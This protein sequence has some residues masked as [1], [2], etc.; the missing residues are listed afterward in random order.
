MDKG[1]CALF[2]AKPGPVTL[3]SLLPRGDEYQVAVLEGEA[4]STPMV[5]PGN[6]LRAHF[7]C[8]AGRLIAWIYDEG[9]G[10]HWMAGYGHVGD[11]IRQWAKIVGAGVR[12]V[13][14]PDIAV[15]P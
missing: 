6:P 15:L 3:V 8:P 4:V 14:P 13:P 2:P 9:I 11:E 12:V 10:H 1:V 5:F 7:R